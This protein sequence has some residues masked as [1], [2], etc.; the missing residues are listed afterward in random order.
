MAEISLVTAGFCLIFVIWL[1]VSS[2]YL[3]MQLERV[4]ELATQIDLRLN[5][6]TDAI[7]KVNAELPEARVIGMEGMCRSLKEQYDEVVT[8]FEQHRAGVHRSMQRF[9][10][11]MRR[12]E[13]A[14]AVI[15][16]EQASQD[17]PDNGGAAELP[18]EGDRSF[19]EPDQ[20]TGNAAAANE[21]ANSW[22]VRRRQMRDEYYRNRAGGPA[23]H[24]SRSGRRAT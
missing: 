12:D 20:A 7:A 21:A 23:I 13:R 14:A 11:I 19:L 24:P 8:A 3:A 18:Q 1:F 2:R 4:A 22:E 17:G 10:Q 15:E 5:A 16:G 9:D 6:A